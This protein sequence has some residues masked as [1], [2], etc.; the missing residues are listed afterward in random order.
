MIYCFFYVYK[1]RAGINE[2]PVEQ[3]ITDGCSEQDWYLWFNTPYLK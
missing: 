2:T 1:E 3:E